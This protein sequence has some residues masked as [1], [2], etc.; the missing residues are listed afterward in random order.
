[1][2]LSTVLTLTDCFVLGSLLSLCV[3]LRRRAVA[4]RDRNPRGRPYPPGPP[5][6]PL[7][8]N[9]LDWPQGNSWLK[10]SEWKKQYGGSLCGSRVVYSLHVFTLC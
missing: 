1:M 8:T 5:G 6:H 10:F 4:S 7:L 9:V 2:V 3:L